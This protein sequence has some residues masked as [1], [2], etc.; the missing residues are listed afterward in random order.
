M[1]KVDRRIRLAF[2]IDALAEAELCGLPR[3]N[4]QPY[5]EAGYSGFGAILFRA[6]RLGAVPWRFAYDVDR[7]EG[8][9]YCL[10]DHNGSIPVEYE[11]AKLFGLTSLE[12]NEGLLEASQVRE[13]GTTPS[14]AEM[15]S[16]LIDGTIVSYL[17]GTRVVGR[18]E[19]A[20]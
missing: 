2:A 10:S 14:F 1:T 4:E 16:A 11:H 15:R 5:G 6:M 12:Y 9:P 13:D 7:A 19:S 18:N 20:T 8:D 17:C 3:G